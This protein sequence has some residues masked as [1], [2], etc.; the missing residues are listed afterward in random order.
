MDLILFRKKIR[1]GELTNEEYTYLI[2]QYYNQVINNNFIVDKSIF[3]NG[4][5]SNNSFHLLISLI[6]SSSKNE[7]KIIE[8]YPLIYKLLTSLYVSPYETINIIKNN[9]ILNNYHCII[10]IKKKSNELPIEYLK[11]IN[12]TQT[13]IFSNLSLFPFQLNIEIH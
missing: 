12:A 8:R 5:K 10:I 1:K 2:N 9:I 7:K 11:N 4:G 6:L 13:I 3:F